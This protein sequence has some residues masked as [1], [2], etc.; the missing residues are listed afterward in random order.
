MIQQTRRRSQNCSKYRINQYCEENRSFEPGWIN[1]TTQIFNS[2]LGQSFQYRNNEELDLTGYIFEFRGRLNDL[3]INLVKLHQLEW[4]DNHT[5]TVKIQMNLYNPNAQLFTVVTLSAEFPF[6][7]GIQTQTDFQPFNLSSE[8]ISTFQLICFIGYI[9]FIFYFMFIHIQSFF[10]W[11]LAYFKQFW[12][13]I[14]LG[15]IVCS[16]TSVGLYAWR[17]RE[18]QRI[19]NLFAETHGYVYLN[20]RLAVYVNDLLTFLL[21]F[22]CFFGTIRFLRLCRYNPRLTLFTRTLQRASNELLSFSMMFSIVFV[23]FISL[24]YLLFTSKIRHCASFFQ[25]AEMLFEMVLMKFDASELIEASAFL[26][27]F[28]F[29]LFVFIIVF[30]CM[31]MFLTILNDSF[32]HARDTKCND[33]NIFGFMWDRFL[34]GTGSK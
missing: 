5:E 20:L 15:I 14:E 32:R 28:A 13:Y 3:R 1:E 33:E 27:P 25:T 7:G 11:K 29:S 4:I 17:Y 24:F 18:A 30:V 23:A 26:G 12:S 2:S 19:G 6:T 34:R 16:W 31:S 22:C 10:H 9:G 21:G 8:F